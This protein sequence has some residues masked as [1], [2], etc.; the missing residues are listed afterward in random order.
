MKKSNRKITMV[1]VIGIGLIVPALWFSTKPVTAKEESPAL[2]PPAQRAFIDPATG[3]F[4]EQPKTAPSTS[5]RA[6]EATAFDTSDE[7]LVEASSAVEEGGM[8]VDLQGRF[9]SP[10]TATLDESGKAMISH[11]PIN[12]TT[13]NN[14]TE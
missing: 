11:D 2:V 14:N 12:S 13:A 8:V 3:G 1:I 7:G 6:A 10:V 4:I 9:R 5:E